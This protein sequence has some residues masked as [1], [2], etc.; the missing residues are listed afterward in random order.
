MKLPNNDTICHDDGHYH[1]TPSNSSNLLS[2]NHTAVVIYG[3]RCEWCIFWDELQDLD[4]KLP[5]GMGAKSYNDDGFSVTSDNKPRIGFTAKNYIIIGYR[6]I[7]YWNK[8]FSTEYQGD[9]M[10]LPND[11]D[12]THRYGLYYISSELCFSSLTVT[13]WGWD[14]QHISFYFFELGQY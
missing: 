2:F 8:L 9:I 3:S 6:I 1:Y 7:R 5:N 4:M 13:V 11:M 12:V 14:G 10:I